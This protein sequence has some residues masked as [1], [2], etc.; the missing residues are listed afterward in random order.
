MADL[1]HFSLC[2]LRLSDSIVRLT[3][4]LTIESNAF[5]EAAELESFDHAFAAVDLRHT[6][7]AL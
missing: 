2:R 6:A 5:I 1:D 4:R 3:T 7:V